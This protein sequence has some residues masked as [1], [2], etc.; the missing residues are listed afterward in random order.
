M[1]TYQQ[2]PIP[3]WVLLKS[4]NPFHRGSL[5]E[6]LNQKHLVGGPGGDQV[7]P[8]MTVHL[9][10]DQA[11]LKSLMP[12]TAATLCVQHKNFLAKMVPLITAVNKRASRRTR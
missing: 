11:H 3:I 10:D 5:F 8:T 7:D 4:S 9:N 2:R 1:Q 12:G 6:N